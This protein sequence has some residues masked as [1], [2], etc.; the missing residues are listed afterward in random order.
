MTNKLGKKNHFY[1]DR[2]LKSFDPESGE[3]IK[4]DPAS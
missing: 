1:E 4:A 2:A 3:S